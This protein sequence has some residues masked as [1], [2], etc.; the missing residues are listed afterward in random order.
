MQTRK[1][2]K[3]DEESYEKIMRLGYDL[4]RAVVLYDMLRKRFVCQLVLEIDR[5][6]YFRSDTVELVNDADASY[7]REELSVAFLF[8]VHSKEVR[9]IL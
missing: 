7:T 1:N 8:P 5:N 2:R 3:N 9:V 4:G 6:V